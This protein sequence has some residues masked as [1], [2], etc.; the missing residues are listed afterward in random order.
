MEEGGGGGIVRGANNNNAGHPPATRRQTI[1]EC[2]GASYDAFRYFCETN[3][4]CMLVLSVVTVAAVLCISSVLAPNSSSETNTFYNVSK[5]VIEVAG[6]ILE[7]SEDDL[8]AG[9][10]VRAGGRLAAGVL[11]LQRS[12]PNETAKI[13]EASYSAAAAVNRLTELLSHFFTG[14]WNRQ[15]VE[16]WG[17]R[18]RADVGAS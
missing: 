13:E 18:T 16:R 8:T 14:S 11:G 12:S 17:N 10:V 9:E 2:L 6:Q 1:L 3:R 5:I 15:K 4:L 7:D